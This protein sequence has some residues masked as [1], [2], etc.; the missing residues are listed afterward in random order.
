MPQTS[1]HREGSIT[2]SDNESNSNGPSSSNMFPRNA[3][4]IDPNMFYNMM[5]AQSMMNMPGMPPGMPPFPPNMPGFH[6]MPPMPPGMMPPFGA[7]GLPPP[8]FPPG[9]PP[10]SDRPNSISPMFEQGRQEQPNIPE[11]ILRQLPSSARPLTVAD[12]ERNL[13]SKN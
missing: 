3:N 11:S 7:G 9:M 13:L 10:S 6:G 1:G 5:M 8:F 2:N 12:L 4:N